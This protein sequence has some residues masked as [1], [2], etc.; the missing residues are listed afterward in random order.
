MVNSVEGNVRGNTRKPTDESASWLRSTTPDARFVSI[1]SLPARASLS[2]TSMPARFP[3]VTEVQTRALF[4]LISCTLR[5]GLRKFTAAKRD[6]G[7]LGRKLSVY[8]LP[9]VDWS[10]RLMFEHCVT[11]NG[12]ADLPVYVRVTQA[13]GHQAWSSPIYLID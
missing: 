12:G 2:Q 1:R 11:F 7:G 13:D 4:G 10:P 3:V 5:S 8:R 9:D 6:A